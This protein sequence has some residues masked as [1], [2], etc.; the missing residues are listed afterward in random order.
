MRALKAF[1]A[2][3]VLAALFALPAAAA[4]IEEGGYPFG[5]GGAADACLPYR[6]LNEALQLNP[7]PTPPLNG[8]GQG[9]NF[10]GLWL[11]LSTTPNPTVR[12]CIVSQCHG[13]PGG[14]FASEWL[15]WGTLDEINKVLVPSG[16]GIAE[17]IGEPPLYFGT[18]AKCDAQVVIGTIHTTAGS[19]TVTRADG[20]RFVLADVGKTLWIPGAGSGG[21]PW[22]P[23]I[24]SVNSPGTSAVTGANSTT[25]A[26]ANAP[27]TVGGAQ[28][29][30]TYVNPVT[31]GDGVHSWAPGETAP[32][33]GGTG[34][35]GQITIKTTEIMSATVVAGGTG[36]TPGYALVTGT[37]GVGVPFEANVT[38][39]SSG[40]ISAVNSI[41]YGGLYTTNP[42]SLAAEPVTGGGVTGATLSLITGAVEAWISKPGNYT[43]IPTGIG[44]GSI[45]GQG[46][47]A[48]TAAFMGSINTSG[49]GTLVVSAISSGLI[50]PGQILVG[51]GVASNTQVGGFSTGGSAGAA[52]GYNQFPV[53]ISQ[54]VSNEPM[55]AGGFPARS[56]GSYWGYGTDDTA[57]IQGEVNAL[58]A[59]GGGVENLP[60]TRLSYCAQT[61]PIVVNQ[62]GVTIHGGGFSGSHA[63]GNFLT[64]QVYANSTTP[65]ANTALLWF[66]ARG[67]KQLDI[68]PAGGALYPLQ[69]D[70]LDGIA[71][72][73]LNSAGW[74]LYM[75]SVEQPFLNFLAEGDQITS[76]D[77]SVNG[78]AYD[79]GV[80]NVTGQFIGA[81][82]G[83]SVDAA[84][85]T[86]VLFG[87]DTLVNN[88]NVS[89]SHIPTINSVTG[90]APAV[91]LRDMDSDI[92]ASIGAFSAAITP[93]NYV[94]SL[95]F[96]SPGTPSSFG[97][98]RFNTISWF[99]GTG[100]WAQSRSG[101]NHIRIDVGDTGSQAPQI[102]PGALLSWD[103]T[104][105]SLNSHTPPADQA[106]DINPDFAIDQANEGGSV[107]PSSSRVWGPDGISGY[108]NVAGDFTIQRLTASPPSG[109]AYYLH[110][111]T[112]AVPT[113][114]AGDIRTVCTRI[115]QGDMRS[116]GWGGSGAV[117]LSVSFLMRAYAYGLYPFFLTNAA[118]TAVWPIAINYTAAGWQQIVF[119]V[120]GPTSYANHWPVTTPGTLGLQLCV[121]A[122][123]GLTYQ[124]AT[125]QQWDINVTP[126]TLPNVNQMVALS[127]GYIDIAQL[128]IWPGAAGNDNFASRP[129]AQELQLAEWRY[130]KTFPLGTAPAQ[131]AGLA[132]ARC[133]AAPSAV[134]GTAGLYLPLD[135]P[136]AATPTLTT[137]NPSAANP[138][139]RDTTAGSDVVV[140]PDPATAI[141]PTGVFIG[142]KTTALT[143]GDPLCLHAT[144][145]A[146]F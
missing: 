104:Q 64:N 39:N 80:Q 97:A 33:T 16:L 67:G 2:A 27:D 4:C 109:E 91:D 59:A 128:R 6:M 60:T 31:P 9:A 86:G 107:S 35:P 88:S 29:G 90:H 53:S 14:Y 112:S 84:G 130:R 10:G 116:L 21:V 136:M 15:V 54:T 95:V 3:G 37:T 32:F 22:T 57:T 89:N 118:G 50:V 129:Y 68:E 76:V 51:S 134:A 144:L 83:Y 137:Y 34:D 78:A 125:P 73:G 98:A 24:L 120:P 62:N 28:Y 66:G 41:Y 12:E 26:P 5:Q 101:P 30:I 69:N 49:G 72:A 46:I 111:A 58:E 102:D 20:G 121:D 96:R 40:Q 131:N 122:G 61:S 70:K 138:N 117:G 13:G 106:L 63:S 93:E 140:N 17:G 113:I 25:G 135:P 56:L 38:I 1:L 119:T 44:N 45:A 43:V 81:D 115:D 36:G 75:R 42:T 65:P 145:D 77:V 142:T 146:R 139:W 133:T 123:S 100:V 99:G 82:D 7:A 127:A 55:T 8:N 23:L 103:S 19:S 47:V 11:D 52:S 141:G 143:P 74:G 124:G 94:Y 132:G 48:N 92:F 105:D 85:T 71:L 87:N 126:F 18:A 79:T 114:G 110:L 108:S